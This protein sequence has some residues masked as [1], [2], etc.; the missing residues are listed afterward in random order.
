LNAHAEVLS[1]AFGFDKLN[2]RCH[3]LLGDYHAKAE[4][5]LVQRGVNTCIVRSNRFSGLAALNG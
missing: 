2:Q 5:T 4:N 3:D 1:K